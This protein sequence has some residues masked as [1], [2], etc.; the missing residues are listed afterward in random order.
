MDPNDHQN[1]NVNPRK[2]VSAATPELQI[3]GTSLRT[4]P[5][6]CDDLEHPLPRWAVDAVG[7]EGPLRQS[8]PICLPKLHPNHPLPRWAVDAGQKRKPT[9]TFFNVQQP[10]VS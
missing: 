2:T 4:I 5:K 1:A 9:Q 6:T 10:V 3:S 7:I 8:S